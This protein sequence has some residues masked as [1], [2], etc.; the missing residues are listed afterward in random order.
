MI[1]EM[2]KTHRRKLQRHLRIALGG[3]RVTC[4]GIPDDYGFMQPELVQLLKARVSNHQP[5]TPGPIQQNEMDRT[6]LILDQKV[7]PIG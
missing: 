3:K 2:E 4:L 6:T 1:F 7:A 5:A